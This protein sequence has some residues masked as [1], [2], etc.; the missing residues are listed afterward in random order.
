MNRRAFLVAVSGI[1]LL[2]SVTVVLAEEFVFTTD[3]R[4]ILLKDD[5]TYLVVKPDQPPAAASYPRKEFED[6]VLDAD[7][8]HGQK[9]EVSGFLMPRIEL[10]ELQGASLSKNSSSE[11]TLW[12]RISQLS[13]EQKRLIL[14]K[15]ASGCTAAVKGEFQ[16]G[17]PSLREFEAHDV[18]I[19][20]SR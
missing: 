15:C 11:L 12:L 1:C 19:R 17:A 20:D 13:R 6:I 10:A 18:Q 16:R 7:K 2:A 8:L 5:G 14:T 3:G 9:I 4:Q